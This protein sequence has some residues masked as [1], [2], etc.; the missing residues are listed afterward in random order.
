[1]NGDWA[2]TRLELPPGE[3]RN[4]LTGESWPAG[5]VRVAD[6]IRKFPVALLYRV[7]ASPGSASP[8]AI[9]SGATAAADAATQPGAPGKENG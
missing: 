8:A 1:M 5:S 2:D 7:P 4:T 6:L 9:S 3:W